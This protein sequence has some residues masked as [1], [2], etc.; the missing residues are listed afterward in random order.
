MTASPNTVTAINTSSARPGARTCSRDAAISRLSARYRQQ[1]MIPISARPYGADGQA[2]LLAGNG[3]PAN[4]YV[5]VPFSRVF[6]SGQYGNVAVRFSLPLQQLHLQPGGHPE[7]DGPWHT[8]RHRQPGIGRR[9]L[10]RE[11]RHLPFRNRDEGRVR[12][13]Q[14]GPDATTSTAYVQGILGASR[15]Q[16][17]LDQLGS[18]PLG[19]A[20]PTRCSPNNPFLDAGHSAAAWGE[21]RL[22]HSGRGG[23]ALP[24]GR[25]CDL[26]ADRQ[27]A[28]AAAHHARISPRL[29]ISGTRSAGKMSTAT[30]TGCIAPSR[31]EDLECG[32]RA[33][34][35]LWPVC[36]W[37]VFYNHSESEL[38]VTNPN[39]TDN[40]K[41]LA[42]LDAVNDGGTHQVLGHVPS[43]SSP[44]S[45]PAACPPTSPIPTGLR[46]RPITICES[47]LMDA[48]TAPG[49]HWRLDRRRSV[50]PGPARGRNQGQP[51]G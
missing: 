7:P 31:S 16:F 14:L 43:R 51:V 18:E 34:R 38:T 33:H 27:H 47:N 46:R 20:A 23:L 17:E 28:A 21:H 4:P 42:S 50:G 11:V 48:E 5:N 2:W 3:S 30:R 32:N 45:I 37:D 22:R 10:L 9:R 13:L 39:N 6:N 41:Y 40:A 29:P 26:A 35:Q 19:R 36:N 15:K 1:D 25:A 12:P 8:H 44:A 24:A 49:Q